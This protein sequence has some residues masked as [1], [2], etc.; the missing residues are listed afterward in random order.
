M[1]WKSGGTRRRAH[2]KFCIPQPFPLSEVCYIRTPSSCT[3]GQPLQV[4][5]GKRQQSKTRLSCS[6]V[7]HQLSPNLSVR[8]LSPGR[9][10]TRRGHIYCPQGEHAR[11]TKCSMHVVVALNE[12]PA[13]SSAVLVQQQLSLL[14]I[15]LAP[16]IDVKMLQAF[17]TELAYVNLQHDL[18]VTSG[19][20][21]Y[22]V[23]RV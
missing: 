20:P 8:P 7:A 19:H 14:G 10:A 12:M 3:A 23:H 18:K 13:G 2:S 1:T 21:R 16:S 6:P 15:C 5:G 4:E 11:M 9:S 17:E 22:T